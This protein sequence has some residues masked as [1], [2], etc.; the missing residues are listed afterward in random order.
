MLC[1]ISGA[2]WNNGSI[3][4]PS[5]RNLNNVRANSNDNYGF[6]S[7]SNPHAAQAVS[8]IQ[9]GAFLR[10]VQAF[11]KFAGRPFSSRHH[12]VLDRLGAFL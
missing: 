11:A 3:A 9:G 10:L 4:G 2:N 8:G 7:D 5:A 6:S 1:V 12:V